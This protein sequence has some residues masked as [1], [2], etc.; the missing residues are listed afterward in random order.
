MDENEIY[1][2]LSS[3]KQALDMIIERID[4]MDEMYHA[5]DQRV[6]ELEKTVREQVL[7]PI[8]ELVEEG[9]KNARFD[10]FDNKY[11]EKLSAFNDT[12]A[13]ME[14]E[15]FD[16][17]RATFDA[18]DALP[19]DQRPDEEAYVNEVTR[20]AEEK[21]N[22]IK[23]A[24]GIPADTATEVTDDGEGNVEVKVDEDGDGEPETPVEEAGEE[25][26]EETEVTDEPDGEEEVGSEESE[27]KIDDPEEIAKLEEE[28]KKEL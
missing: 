3:Y 16:L 15:G 21:I 26:S 28:L 19:E 17:S 13:P 14:E 18:Y 1:E 24:F 25:V 20:I 7:D 2:I 8:N 6:D 9:E 4:Q 23:E 27:E 22:Q 5:A 12:L 10:E 11:G